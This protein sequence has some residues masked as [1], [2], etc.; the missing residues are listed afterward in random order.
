MESKVLHGTIT[1]VFTLDSLGGWQQVRALAYFT[2][3]LSSLYYSL[4]TSL[5]DSDIHQCLKSLSSEA[6]FFSP[7]LFVNISQS[8][9]FFKSKQLG[10]STIA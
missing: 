2:S 6:N 10:P 1:A 4:G 9:S 8:L 5:E 7:I 3:H